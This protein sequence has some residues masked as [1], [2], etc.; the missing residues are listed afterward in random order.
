MIFD[1]HSGPA[2]RSRVALPRATVA[3]VRLVVNAGRR[4]IIVA[5]ALEL[6]RAVSLGALLILSSEL[7]SEIMHVTD[8]RVTWSR[9]VPDIAA[10]AA[11]SALVSVG[12]AVIAR[13]YQLLGELT[14]RSAQAGILDVACSV[15]LAAFDDP[16]FYDLMAR[17]QGAVAR[18]G[19]IVNGLLG[20]LQSGTS[21]LATL[22]A[23]ALLNPLLLPLALLAL[24]PGLMVSSRRAGAYYRFAVAL[25]PRDRERRYLAD[26]L[27]SRDAAKEVRAMALLAP[28]LERYGTLYEER[29]A[30]LRTVVRKQLA[31]GV[32]AAL[33]TSVLLAGALLLLVSLVAGG[34][35]SLTAAAAAA[36][37]TVLLGQRI[38]MASASVEMLLESAMLVE[39]YFG[40]LAL[41]P[42]HNPPPALDASRPSRI[43]A[44]SAS[45]VTAED[46]WFTYRGSAT[47]SLRGASLEIAPGE[48]VALVGANGSGKTTLAKLLTGLYAPDRGRIL[49]NGHDATRIDPEDL[50]RSV[51]V[52]FQDF[53]RYCLAAYDNVAFGS[54]ER[55]TDRHGVTVAAR[56]AGIHDVIEALPAGYDTQLGPAF[57]GGVDL[58][59]GQWQKLALARLFFRDAPFVVLD[60]PTAALDAM[61]EHDLFARIREL[62]DRRSVLLIS[63]RFST[64]READ[65]IYVMEDGAITESGSHAELMQLEGAYAGMFDLQ[66]SAYATAPGSAG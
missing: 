36:A 1:Q 22:V 21:G 50:R 63:H 25:T 46:V 27:T 4:E 32:A 62:F 13:Q 17:A 52:V 49:V 58:S 44:V 40:F 37:A 65:R 55:Y 60:E 8:G 18:S 48:V 26:L 11:L 31:W 10:L 35:L 54:H 61:A 51:G 5:V 24:V 45:S 64:V 43:S 28:L 59:I 42:A 14:S 38:S 16:D 56:R 34:H 15:E 29:I 39:N 66:A 7:L 2:S 3:A 9:L 47:P 19:Q 12:Q 57:A 30:E 33:I 41:R 20:L 53:T 23:L 6:L